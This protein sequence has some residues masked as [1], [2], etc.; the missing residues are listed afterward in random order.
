M[1]LPIPED[2]LGSTTFNTIIQAYSN[3]SGTLVNN[4]LGTSCT[5]VTVNESV[6]T[7]LTETLV[8][9]IQTLQTDLL[10]VKQTA[11]SNGCPG[12]VWEIG[13]TTTT[14]FGDNL[15]YKGRN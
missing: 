11:N 13:F 1:N 3:C 8:T 7:N 9:E 12:F 6:N 15:N 4:S 5:N 14:V 10:E 2:K